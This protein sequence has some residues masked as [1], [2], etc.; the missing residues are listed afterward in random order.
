[1]T[2]HQAFITSTSEREKNLHLTCLSN[3]SNSTLAHVQLYPTDVE[4]YTAHVLHNF[5]KQKK[6]KPH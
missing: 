4:F 5:L 2:T 6:N 3:G 1:M